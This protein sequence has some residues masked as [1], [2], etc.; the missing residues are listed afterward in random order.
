[1]GHGCVDCFATL[2]VI[3]GRGR[4]RFGSPDYHWPA[5][6]LSLSGLRSR[7]RFVRW[8]PL[9]PQAL[10][11]R[12]AMRLWLCDPAKPSSHDSPVPS[13]QKATATKLALSTPKAPSVVSSIFVRRSSHRGASTGSMNRSACRSKQKMSDRSL[14]WRSTRPRLRTSMSRPRR[15]LGFTTRPAPLIGWR[16]CGAETVVPALYTSLTQPTGTSPRYFPG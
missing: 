9:L 10:W 12:R 5:V 2:R 7:F 3:Q 16:A 1:M 8:C 14:V 15:L 6:T 11:H 4:L 13:L